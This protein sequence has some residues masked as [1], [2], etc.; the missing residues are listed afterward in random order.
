M[1]LLLIVAAGACQVCLL[2]QASGRDGPRGAGLARWGSGSEPRVVGVVGR[3][4]G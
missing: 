4:V 2:E 3:R 1:G